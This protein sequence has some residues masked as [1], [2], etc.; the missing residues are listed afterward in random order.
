MI[1]S[2]LLLWKCSKCAQKYQKTRS[3]SCQLLPSTSWT[4]ITSFYDS[5]KRRVAS[6]MQFVSTVHNIILHLMPRKINSLKDRK[7]SDLVRAHSEKNRRAMLCCWIFRRRSADCRRLSCININTF[8]CCESLFDELVRSLLIESRL[9]KQK[10]PI[11]WPSCYVV[12]VR[13]IVSFLLY[14]NDW[15]K[16]YC[17]HSVVRLRLCRIEV[18]I[19]SANDHMLL[20]KFYQ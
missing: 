4:F 6:I 18:H 20:Q 16:L 15:V 10:L 17:I 1:R 8:T 11:S 2:V 9:S 3:H 5:E 19:S 7:L 14:L 12:N 13:V